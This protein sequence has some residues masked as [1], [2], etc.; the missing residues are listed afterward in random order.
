MLAFAL[1]VTA[2]DVAHIQDLR[3]QSNAAIAAHDL[4]GTTR[5]IDPNVRVLRSNGGFVDGG[6]AMSEVYAQAFADPA[7]VTYI[8]TP[9]QIVVNGMV[10][11][12]IGHWTGIWR[13]Y[14]ITGNYLTRWSRQ[15]DG[16][17]KI[18]AEMYAPMRC[19]GDGCPR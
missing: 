7:F 14:K 5:L 9:K 15:A 10:A 6:A 4:S 16:A 1:A 17:W 13:K 2:M 18:V 3:N 19:K 8:R 12:E 11:S